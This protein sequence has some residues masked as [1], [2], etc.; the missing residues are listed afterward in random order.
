MTDIA[1]QFQGRALACP[2]I[3]VQARFFDKTVPEPMSG[4]LL[5]IGAS[6]PGGYGQFWAGGK[7][8]KAH[9]V[10]YAIEHDGLVRG[11]DVMH[12][13]DTPACVNPD[14]L[15]AAPTAENIRDAFN[16]GRLHRRGDKN[17]RTKVPDDMVPV[18]QRLADAGVETAQIAHGFDVEVTTVRRIIAGT[19]NTA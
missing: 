15:R 6:G 9:R 4:C 13:C 10:A 19:R 11:L 1:D 17:S 3:D 16:K 5:W 14:H 2:T 12:L 7:C 8:Q 18:I